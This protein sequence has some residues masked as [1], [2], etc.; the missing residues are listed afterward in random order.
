MRPK[1]ADTF[2]ELARSNPLTLLPALLRRKRLQRENTDATQRADEEK[3]LRKKYALQLAEVIREAKLPLAEQ[4]REVE[5]PEEVWPRIFG[6]RRSKTLRNRLKA[7]IHFRGWLQCVHGSLWPTNVRQLLDYSNERYRE[8]CGKT[9]L[10]SF[11]AAL[12]VLEQVGKVPEGGRMS[13]GTTWLAH[14]RSLTADLVSEQGPVVQAP[15]MTVAMVVSLE[16]HVGKE[17]EPEYFRAMAFIALLAIYGSLRMDDVQGILP[18]T[19]QLSDQGFRAV[20]GRTKTTGSDRRNKEVSVFIHRQAGLSGFDWLGAGFNLWKGY[21]K[22]RDYLV[23]SVK[24]D[25]KGPTGHF[26]KAEVVASY[27]RD[28]RGWPR[29]S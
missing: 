25:W 22:P 23:M 14:L 6:T 11:Q 21:T 29:P 4:L 9:V 5:K 16:L 10:N 27:V 18:A 2:D 7:W 17:N 19:M 20:L 8:G 24:D 15:L 3:L 1:L 26:V 12:A 28:S 13:T